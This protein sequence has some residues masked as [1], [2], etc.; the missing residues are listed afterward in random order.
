MFIWSHLNVND[1]CHHGSL[2]M[3]ADLSA[4]TNRVKCYKKDR[5]NKIRFLL[6]VKINAETKTCPAVAVH[7][8]KHSIIPNP[9]VIYN[10]A[11][12]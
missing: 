3:R 2:D 11:G 6:L 12:N 5:H 4:M 7:L 8:E 10:L 9:I 1:I